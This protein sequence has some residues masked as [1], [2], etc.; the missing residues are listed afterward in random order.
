MGA[1]YRGRTKAHPWTVTLIARSARFVTVRCVRG[2][3]HARGRTFRMPLRTFEE[4][5]RPD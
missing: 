2:P 5:Y 3:G 1:R 4:N